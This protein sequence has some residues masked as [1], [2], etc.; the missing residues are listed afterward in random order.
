MTL[1]SFINRYEEHG[2]G[3]LP[4]FSWTWDDAPP[5]ARTG[6]VE[7]LDGFVL[8]LS[9]WA[10]RSIRFD[11]SLGRFHGYDLDFCLQVREAG[12]QGRDGRLPRD[13]PPPARDAPG[14][15][16]VDRGPHQ[17]SPRS[18]TAACRASAPAPGSWRERAL[19]AEAE[20]DAA[21][22]I[23]AHA[24]ARARGARPR[25]RARPRRDA[26]EPLVAAHR[27][28][29]VARAVA[30]AGGRRR[31]SRASPDDRVRLRDR[32]PRGRTGATRGRASGAPPSPTPR[33]YAFAAVGTI[34]PQLQPAARHRRGATTTSRRSCSCDPHAEIADPDFCATVRAGAARS[35]GRG[36]RAR[37]AR[38]DVRTIAWWEG[39][40]QLRR[41]SST[42][43][44]STA[45]ASWPA[46]AWAGPA[47]RSARSTRS[48]AYCWCCR[49]GRCATIRF[50]ESLAHRPRL[51]PRLLPA[52]PRGRAAGGHRR[53]ARDPPPHAR[54]ACDDLDLWVEAHIKLAEQVGRPLAGRSGEPVDWKA[55]RPPRRGRARG[56]A[57]DG[58]LEHA[59]GVDARGRWRSSASWTR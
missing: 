20:R 19:R 8:A 40:G 59:R 28:A 35:G 48:T 7:T 5:Y 27:S 55:P 58:L 47:R 24:G 53:P 46:Y 52:G 51:R 30:H 17:R 56:G 3:D 57:D 41:R 15:G 34:V 49:P 29:A 36:R 14:P 18:G 21:A 4:S 39:D 22:A 2:G 44:T 38:R 42:A 1:A 50:D 37:S 45:A 11:E 25:A 33:C 10:V 13:P 6:E 54:A 31:A 16:G 12:P 26:R 43:T 9:P 23:G 32:R